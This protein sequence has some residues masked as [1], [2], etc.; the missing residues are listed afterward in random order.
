M[1]AAA[2][3]RDNRVLH[4]AVLVSIILH[5]LA[6][7]AAPMLR[8]S[9][10]R[11]AVWPAPIVA[12]LA[13]PPPAP[14]KPEPPAIEPAADPAPSPK[15]RPVAKTAP[16]APPE[17]APAAAAAATPPAEPPPSTPAVP[18][19]APAASAAAAP[20]DAIDADSLARFRMEVIEAARKVK[21]YP[22][23]AQ[24]NNWEG[25]ASV[26]V[27]FGSDGRRT[28]IVI[29]RSSGYE[30]L[31]TQAIDTVTRA[32]VPVPPALRGKAFAF[33][34]QIIFDLKDNPSG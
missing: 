14:A 17:P 33:E 23:A 25:K 29:A 28:S 2:H 6:L 27:S 20:A 15:A 31:D 26:R 11:M 8:D 22:R 12:R 9:A 18:G 21:R 1:S 5:G 16:K 34:I 4:Y 32:E 30:I 13:Q 10:R 24:D 7:L 3:G 19:A